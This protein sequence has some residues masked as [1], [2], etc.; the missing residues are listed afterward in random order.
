MSREQWERMRAHVDACLPLEA[1][2]LLAG[3]DANVREVLTIRNELQSSSRFRMAA[4]EQVRAF[5]DI[6]ARELDLVG[7][8]HSHPAGPES[9]EPPAIQPSDTDVAEAVYPVVHVLWSHPNG[10]WDARG[11][12][13]EGGLVSEVAL[14]ISDS[15]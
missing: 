12:W 8:F 11:Y 6:E 7:I 9:A 2:G 3:K 13:I 14:R 1:C 15:E 4:A 5:A 10:S